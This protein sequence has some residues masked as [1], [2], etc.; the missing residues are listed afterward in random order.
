MNWPEG[1]RTLCREVRSIAHSVARCQLVGGTLPSVEQ[2]PQRHWDDAIAD[3]V[4]HF[5]SAPEVRTPAYEAWFQQHVLPRL[6]KPAVVTSLQWNKHHEEAEHPV[7]LLEEGHSL[8][9]TTASGLIFGWRL[10]PD[11]R[12]LFFVGHPCPE[13]S[14]GNGTLV[15]SLARSG[16]HPVT[17][18]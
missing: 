12:T 14:I 8:R 2:L 13:G 11:Y 17:I 6:N 7:E 10:L 5:G 9:Y 16:W 3:A 15:Q 1:W 4:L 18:S